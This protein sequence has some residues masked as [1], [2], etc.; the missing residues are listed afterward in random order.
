MTVLVLGTSWCS[1]W[2]EPCSGP[3]AAW[4]AFCFSP[5]MSSAQGAEHATPR[6]EGRSLM[7]RSQVFPTPAISTDEAPTRVTTTL[8]DVMAALQT[9]VE[10]EDD[11]I[12]VAIVAAWLRSGRLRVPEDATIAA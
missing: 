4:H 2:R 12:V 8:Y 9:V 10:P 6:T 1:P 3:A 5:F 7:H 11:D